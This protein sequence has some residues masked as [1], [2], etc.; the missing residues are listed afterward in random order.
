MCDEYGIA[1]ISEA[2]AVG[3]QSVNMVRARLYARSSSAI[4]HSH[5]P[6]SSLLLHIHYRYARRYARTS[7]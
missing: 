1:V 7:T 2:P 6:S 5:P 4:T 3:L